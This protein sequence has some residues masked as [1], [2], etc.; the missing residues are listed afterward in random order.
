MVCISKSFLYFL[1]DF[2]VRRAALIPLYHLSSKETTRQS[3][4]E[5]DR[6]ANFYFAFP[7][8][9]QTLIDRPEDQWPAQGVS[10]IRLVLWLMR[11]IDFGDSIIYKRFPR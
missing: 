11:N 9:G 3:N 6:V 4:T 8:T 2:S 5:S 10:L 7:E 1:F